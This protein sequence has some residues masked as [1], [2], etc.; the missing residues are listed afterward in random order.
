MSITGTLVVAVMAPKK[1]YTK[2][3]MGLA[4]E[5]VAKGMPTATAAKTYSVPRVTLLYKSRG[6]LPSTAK[7][8]RTPF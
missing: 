7:W 5:A 8:E 2:E 6:K 4:L 1:N 3:Q